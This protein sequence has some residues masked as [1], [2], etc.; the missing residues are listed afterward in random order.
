[1][2]AE[3]EAGVCVKAVD[4]NTG[5]VWVI[6]QTY[7]TCATYKQPASW[8]KKTL[9]KEAEEKKKSSRADLSLK[10]AWIRV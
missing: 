2:T 6:L 7:S 4:S 1:M 10:G 9:K 3:C 8:Q 5:I